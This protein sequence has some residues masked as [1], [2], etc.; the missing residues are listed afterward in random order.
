MK[1]VKIT[2]TKWN[3]MF[4]RIAKGLWNTTQTCGYKKAGYKKSL[5]QLC[6]NKHTYLKTMYS[7]LP[8]MIFKF[9]RNECSNCGK[10][11]VGLGLNSHWCILFYCWQLQVPESLKKEFMPP[12][13]TKEL[14][15]FVFVHFPIL[16][17]LWSYQ[18]KF[19]IGDITAGITVSVMYIP[20]GQWP[21]L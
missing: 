2:Y 11:Q 7:Y 15:Q 1:L 21:L 12:R 19:L 8:C 16:S 3:K 13:T 14:K 4:C 17:W 5:F 9:K 20:Q 10:I 18:P 6:N